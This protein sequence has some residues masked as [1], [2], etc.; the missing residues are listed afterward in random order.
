M[1]Y[2]EAARR[3]VK[4]YE[5]KASRLWERIEVVGEILSKITDKQ[6]ELISDYLILRAQCAYGIF[7]AL[8]LQEWRSTSVG[9]GR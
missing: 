8:R 1:S 6:F 7:D 3:V 4:E 2:L 5:E 9:S